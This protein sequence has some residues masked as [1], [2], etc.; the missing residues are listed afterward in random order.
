MTP[1]LATVVVVLAVRVAVDGAFV[2][3]FVCAVV[4]VFVVRF[5]A[6]SSAARPERIL[7]SV[8]ELAF[9]VI[10]TTLDFCEFRFLSTCNVDKISCSARD[11]CS[12]EQPSGLPSST[13]IR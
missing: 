2:C 10:A 13:Q 12:E 7:G 9:D 11:Q 4:F 6:T 1:D 3:N 8:A 5:A